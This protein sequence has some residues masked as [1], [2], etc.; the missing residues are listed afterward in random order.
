MANYGGRN[1]LYLATSVKSPMFVSNVGY[2]VSVGS[3]GV[4]FDRAIIKLCLYSPLAYTVHKIYAQV[5][6]FYCMYCTVQCITRYWA[7][8]MFLFHHFCTYL[9]SLKLP[10]GSIKSLITEYCLGTIWQ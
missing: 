10:V 4:F 2:Y 5:H 7:I 8:F 1:G 6:D 3:V 9:D